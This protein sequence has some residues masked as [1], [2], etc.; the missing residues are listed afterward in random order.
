M[1]SGDAAS[2]AASTVSAAIPM[3]TAGSGWTTARF[4][5]PRIAGPHPTDRIRVDPV[6]EQPDARIGRGLARTDDHVLRGRSA[7]LDQFVD[8]H[9]VHP[10]GDAERRRRCPP[11][12]RGER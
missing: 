10:V 12:S 6:V 5:H 3:K 7:E 2:A 9:D 8:W 11:V 4:E 1:S